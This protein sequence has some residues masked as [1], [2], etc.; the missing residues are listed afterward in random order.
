MIKSFNVY[1][2]R[3]NNINDE[4]TVNLHICL[5]AT[6]HIVITILNI[7]A[8]RKFSWYRAAPIGISMW[9]TN[10]GQY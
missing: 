10:M 2:L 7:I 1:V 5:I 6:S 8:D 3:T 4:K 9:F